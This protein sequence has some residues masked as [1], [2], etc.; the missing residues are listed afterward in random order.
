[1]SL[2]L[3][4]LLPSASRPADSKLPPEELWAVRGYLAIMQT[5]YFVLPI[6]DSAGLQEAQMLFFPS[7]PIG[8]YPVCPWAPFP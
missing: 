6:R 8:K 5:I 1:M 3:A 2:F 7:A 4:A